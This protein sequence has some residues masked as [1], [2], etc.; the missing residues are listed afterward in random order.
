MR[1]SWLLYLVPLA[2]RGGLAFVL[3]AASP[4]HVDSSST[5]LQVNAPCSWSLPIS[6]DP[7][8]ATRAIARPSAAHRQHFYALRMMAKNTPPTGKTNYRRPSAAIERGGGFFVPGLE[9]F[10][11]RFALGVVILGLLSLEGFAPPGMTIFQLVSKLLA[12]LAGVSLFAQALLDQ[13][14]ERAFEMR[15]EA[16]AAAPASAGGPGMDTAAGEGQVAFFDSAALGSDLEAKVM[17][18][19]DIALQL[20]AAC[21]FVMFS[22]GEVLARVGATGGESDASDTVAAAFKQATAAAAAAAAAAQAGEQETGSPSAAVVKRS[23]NGDDN[24]ALMQLLPSAC[25][26]GVLC[27][28]SCPSSG[29]GDGGGDLMVLLGSTLAGATVLSGMDG[30]WFERVCAFLALGPAAVGTGER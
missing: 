19:A 9:G 6:A 1:P 2:S 14:K 8:D 5:L 3:P 23:A 15:R 20:T 11:A 12:G 27:R 29:R 28:V 22:D 25:R 16:I 26:Q 30:A 17:W 13:Q 10:K 24:D 21:S 7:A 18:A 4:L